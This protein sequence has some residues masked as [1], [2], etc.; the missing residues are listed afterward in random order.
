MFAVILAFLSATVSD[1][2]PFS[3]SNVVT[4]N[5]QL[6]TQHLQSVRLFHLPTSN[7]YILPN[8]SRAQLKATPK[9]TTAEKNEAKQSKGNDK[10]PQTTDSKP[11]PQKPIDSKTASADT[12]DPKKTTKDRENQQS[13][14]QASSKQP[15]EENVEPDEEDLP[16]ATQ[17]AKVGK[18]MSAS[19][20][21]AHAREQSA[22]LMKGGFI[23]FIEWLFVFILVAPGTFPA[24]G[25]VI[26]SCTSF[27]RRRLAGASSAATNAVTNAATRTD[28]NSTATYQRVPLSDNGALTAR[29]RGKVSDERDAEAL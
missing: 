2:V 22:G 18:P 19:E 24:I 28:T 12:K 17:E 16:V 27:W 26:L 21:I 23:E 29:A 6:P 5:S 3:A 13:E 15:P 25:C 9:Q 14:S 20:M 11:P 1:A 7:R 8:L 10:S 4:S